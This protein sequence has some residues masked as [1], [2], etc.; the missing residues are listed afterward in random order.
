MTRLLRPFGRDLRAVLDE[1]VASSISIAAPQ[2]NPPVGEAEVAQLPDAA[3]RYL[4]FMGVVGRPRDLWLR[5]HLRGRFRMRVGQK[6]MPCESWQYNSGTEIARLFHMRIDFAGMVPMVGRDSYLRGRGRMHGKLLGLVTVAD[7]HGPETDMS[8]LTTYLND[9]VMMAPSML[10]RPEVTWSEV[11]RDTFAV[12]LTDSGTKVT[13]RVFVDEQGAPRDFSTTDRYADLPGGPVRAEW[14]TPIDGW[15][16]AGGRS[17]PTR[18]SA[19]WHLSDG[20]LTYAEFTF[21]ANSIE[22]PTAA[23]A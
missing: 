16:H 13:A 10:L 20:P 21:G 22:Y 11:D 12:A 23:T 9:A 7:A 19:V 17:V 6:F 3:Q 1:D 8:E 18:G 14:T 4:R 5:A 15:T 2:A